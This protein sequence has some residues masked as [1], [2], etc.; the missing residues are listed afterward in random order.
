MS[1]QDPEVYTYRGRSLEELVGRIR[2]D[3]GDDAVIVARRETRSGGF[4]GFFAKR[5]IEVDVKPATFVE[6]LYD[7][8]VIAF[9]PEKKLKRD[10]GVACTSGASTGSSGA[11]PGL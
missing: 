10:F 3:L 11:L 5:E 7:E 6:P 4:A 2:D 1:G 9:D 8:P